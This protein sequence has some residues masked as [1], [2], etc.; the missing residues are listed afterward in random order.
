MT[1]RHW[2]VALTVFGWML[3]LQSAL[4]LASGVLGLLARGLLSPGD[5]GA[6]VVGAGELVPGYEALP[7][8]VA[9]LD[10]ALRAGLAVNAAQL[11][12][13]VGLLRRRKWGWYVT[14]IVHVLVAG[15]LFAFLPTVFGTVL[16]VA[17]PNES[18]VMPWLLS[19]LAVL[20]ALAVVGFLLLTPVVRQFEAAPA[21]GKP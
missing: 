5:I 1:D 21:P 2:R 16:T 15:G 14:V 7:G 17:A 10:I 18:P 9:M 8:L 3:L 6:G 20:P 11:A 13:A 12:G 4:G 19:L